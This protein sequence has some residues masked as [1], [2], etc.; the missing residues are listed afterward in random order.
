MT[1]EEGPKPAEKY[2]A[3]EAPPETRRKEEYICGKN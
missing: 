3:I 1:V 2:T